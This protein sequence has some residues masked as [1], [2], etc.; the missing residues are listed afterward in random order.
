MVQSAQRGTLAETLISRT[1]VVFIVSSEQRRHPHP[2]LDLF[3]C[4]FAF[5]ND[6]RKRLRKYLY[7]WIFTIKPEKW[8]W[9]VVY[10]D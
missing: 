9:A 4:I 1:E 6:L 5:Y 3:I 7:L 8:H 2:I 10:A